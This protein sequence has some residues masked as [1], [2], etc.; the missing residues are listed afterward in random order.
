MFQE[1]MNFSYRRTPLQ[2]LGW[3]LFFLFIGGAIGFLAGGVAGTGSTALIGFQRGAL[4]GNITA[5]PY[6]ITLGILLLW[7]RPKGVANILLAL[8]GAVVSV[9]LGAVGGLIPL[10]ALT[11]RPIAANAP[12]EDD[13][14]KNSEKPSAQI[15][16]A[17][18]GEFLN[19]PN[20]YRYYIE[21]DGS[22]S[23]VN[24][25]GKRMA[26]ANWRSFCDA[27]GT[28]DPKVVN[29]LSLPSSGS[30]DE[31]WQTF[32]EHDPSISE[33]VERLSS[34]SPRNVEEFRTLLLQH[35]DCSRAKEFEDEAIRRIQGP[36]FIGDP[37]LREAY[38]SLN[39]E[40][41]RLG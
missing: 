40:D 20:G 27:T 5:V 32:L 29:E 26:F 39:R 13:G 8:A 23:A 30:N 18:K 28:E 34:L 11:T 7:N 41:G 31:V 17:L 14:Q 25:Q 2:A 15:A 6:H 36:A 4:A 21:K 35:R 24:V 33:T 12:A 3:Y 1:L 19:E 16:D 22:V 38:I 9:L 37:T 10:A